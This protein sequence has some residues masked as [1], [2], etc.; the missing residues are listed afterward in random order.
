M[1]LISRVANYISKKNL[2]LMFFNIVNKSDE[3]KCQI[4][5]TEIVYYDVEWQHFSRQ[6][7]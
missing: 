6:K 7:L 3:M 2:D 1:K 5:I 4:T